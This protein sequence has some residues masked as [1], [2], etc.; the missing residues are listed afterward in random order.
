MTGIV[1]RILMAAACAVALIASG[2]RAAEVTEVKIARQYG[3]GYLPMMIMEQERLVEKHAKLAGL[4]AITVTWATFAGANVMTDALL[5][6]DLHFAAVGTTLVPILWARTQGG[7]QEI[8]GVCGLSS[9]P[10]FLNTRN[11]KIRSVK[12]FGAGD[13]IALP[14][15]KVS[16]MAVVLQMAAEQAFGPGQHDKLDALTVSR[17]HP[18]GM[19]ALLSGAGEIN[20]HFTWPPFQYRELRHPGIRTVLASNDVLGGSASTVVIVAPARF[21]AANPKIF[22]A[23]LAAMKE[24][25]ELIRNDRRRAAELYLRATKDMD[26][27]E[28]IVEMLNPD[29]F[30]IVPQNVMKFTE[31]LHR[32]GVV[33][34]KPASWKEMFFP[35]V[36]DLPGS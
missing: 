24:A 19:T 20:S 10:L 14:A 16:T 33:K 35:E 25:N 30:T 15:V 7:P 36:A 11:P 27:V 2:A 6:G 26:T 32:V 13:R 29:H 9:V 31:F 18:D 4:P 3:I 8:L 21:R 34:R 22:G 1:R 5:S 12:D 17:S 28:S 23:Y